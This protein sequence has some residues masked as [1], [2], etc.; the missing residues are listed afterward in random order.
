MKFTVLTLFPEMLRPY[1]DESILKRAQKNKKISIDIINIRDFTTDRHHTA[2][3]KP[4]G[5]GPGML[6]KAEPIIRAFKKVKKTKGKQKVLIMSA[7]G[8]KFTNILAQHYAKRYGSI[9]CIA[10]RY[11]GIDERIKKI[12]HAEEVSI[13]DYVLTGGELPA[14]VVVDAVSRHIPGV[15]GDIESIEENRYGAGVPMYTRPEVLEYKGK[16][17]RVPKELLSG[18]HAIISLW[19]QKH[20]KL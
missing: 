5:G 12:L 19:R 17:Y 3:D 11:E 4:Y 20:R 13:G 9:V 7:Q 16:S 18:N 6:M 8:K 14:A 1:F 10:G 2:D 15:L